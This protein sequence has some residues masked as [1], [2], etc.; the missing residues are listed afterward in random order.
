MANAQT[1][2]AGDAQAVFET[3]MYR[4]CQRQ[5]AGLLQ[6]LTKELGSLQSETPIENRICGCTVG[7]LTDTPR[8]KKVFENP[9]NLK[10]LGEDKETLEFVKRK[11]ASLLLQCTGVVLDR[12]VDPKAR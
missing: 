6:T 5:A 10:N 7:A 1:V 11:T 3:L 8:V 4:N 9:E 2:T 12:I